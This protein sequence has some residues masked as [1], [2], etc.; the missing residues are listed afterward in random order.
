M[1]EYLNEKAKFVCTMAIGP[2]KFTC[3]EGKNN[4]V[5]CGGS[6]VLTT[7]AKLQI[8]PGLNCK[9]L[10]STPEP[11]CKLAPTGWIP[12]DMKNTA[13]GANLLTKASKNICLV[14]GI[15]SVD[16]SGVEGKFIKI[17]G[18]SN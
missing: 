5:T 16:D 11:F 9:M 1:P 18:T 14:G 4:K 8:P 15:I 7:Q 13:E 3:R 2:A 17:S 6:K 10:V 12:F